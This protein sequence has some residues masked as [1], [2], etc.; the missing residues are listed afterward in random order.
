MVA[1]CSEWLISDWRSYATG[2]R[3]WILTGSGRLI[4]ATH[5]ARAWTTVGSFL[6]QA[7]DQRLAQRSHR[8]HID[9]VVDDLATLMR[10]RPAQL[11]QCTASFSNSG[12]CSAK[13]EKARLS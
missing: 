10:A 8:Q 4:T 5:I 12:Q 9:S 13:R 11:L 3:A 6:T 2:G 1:A 7:D